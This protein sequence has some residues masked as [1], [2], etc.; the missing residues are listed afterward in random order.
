MDKVA[1][2]NS[3]FPIKS[4]ERSKVIPRKFGRLLVTCPLGSLQ[5][6]PRQ[7]G[8]DARAL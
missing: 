6:K 3:S 2:I 7:L 5:C 8:E 4:M 1:L